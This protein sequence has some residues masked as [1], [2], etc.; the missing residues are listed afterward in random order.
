MVL[1]YPGEM[2]D[3]VRAPFDTLPNSGKC[4]RLFYIDQLC[5]CQCWCGHYD[6]VKIIGSLLYIVSFAKHHKRKSKHG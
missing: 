4:F 2:Y 1:W 5:K 6:S 3:S